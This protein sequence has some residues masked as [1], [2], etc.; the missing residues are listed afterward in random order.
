MCAVSIDDLYLS[1]QRN[2]LTKYLKDRLFLNDA[3]PQCV[4]RL[5]AHHQDRVPL[6]ARA[7]REVM[8]DAAVLHHSRRSNDH[9]GPVGT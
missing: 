6:I 9:H 4:L 2:I 7:L 3:P 8:K 5:K 1:M